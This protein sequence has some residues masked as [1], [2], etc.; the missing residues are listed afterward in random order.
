VQKRP[1]TPASLSHH[2]ALVS[3]RSPISITGA[4]VG[5][6]QRCVYMQLPEERLGKSSLA[7][8]GVPYA[9]PAPCGE[10]ITVH[11][12]LRYVLYDI[13]LQNLSPLLVA[14][15]PAAVHSLTRRA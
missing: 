6:A 7:R 5:H 15:C 9:C 3:H 12:Y 14:S 2:A 13:G 11:S 1:L 4:F 8:L 10:N